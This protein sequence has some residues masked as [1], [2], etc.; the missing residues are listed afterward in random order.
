MSDTDNRRRAVQIANQLPK[1]ISD[2]LATLAYCVQVIRFTSGQT[3]AVT[4]DGM[5]EI[6]V[7]NKAER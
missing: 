5:L 2:A 6:P 3:D 7:G 1:N 4:L